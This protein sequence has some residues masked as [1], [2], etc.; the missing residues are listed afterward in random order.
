MCIRDSRRVRSRPFQRRA[1]VFGC[2]KPHAT[3]NRVV[4]PAPLGPMTPSTWFG[5]TSSETSESAWMPPKLTATSD[6]AKASP[7]W[8][9]RAGDTTGWL[10][11]LP[12][13]MCDVANV[14][15]G[16]HHFGRRAQKMKWAERT[17]HLV[18]I[19]PVSYTHLRA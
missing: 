12:S 10:T 13:Q 15:C 11:D 1:P 14:R 18:Q 8:S 19:A 4:L 9:L 7:A 16:V 5:A 6:I 2:T 3:L 17:S